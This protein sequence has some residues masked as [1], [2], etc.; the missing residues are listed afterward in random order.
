MTDQVDDLEEKTQVK[1]Y[2]AAVPLSRL[3]VIFF[4]GKGVSN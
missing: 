1:K 3:V 4:P 2:D